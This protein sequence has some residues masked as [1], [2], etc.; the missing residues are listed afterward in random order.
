VTPARRESLAVWGVVTGCALVGLALWRVG[1]LLSPVAAICF[2]TMTI[3]ALVQAYR[4]LRRYG[5]TW[6]DVAREQ[7]RE[8]ERRR[9]S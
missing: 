9:K 2:P 6:P 5:R 4:A 1:F 3:V 8:L 7:M